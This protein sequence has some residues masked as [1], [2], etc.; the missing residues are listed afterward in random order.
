MAWVLPPESPFLEPCDCPLLS[1]ACPGLHTI[2]P[3]VPCQ[4]FPHRCLELHSSICLWTLV[5][6][7]CPRP[8]LF[9]FHRAPI[10]WSTCGPYCIFHKTP[11]C[12]CSY[13]EPLL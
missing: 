11:G 10:A 5:R 13:H 1:T 3:L 12:L 9:P 4:P 7:P 2:T 6:S 8:A